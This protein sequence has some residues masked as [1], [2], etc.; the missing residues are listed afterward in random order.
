[1]YYRFKFRSH[2]LFVEGDIANCFKETCPTVWRF[3]CPQETYKHV[4]FGAIL[5]TLLRR[6][7]VIALEER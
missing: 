5:S 2:L 7:D 3:L 6:W 1:M 4:C